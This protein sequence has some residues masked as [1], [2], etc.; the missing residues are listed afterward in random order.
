MTPDPGAQLRHD[1]RTPLNHIIGYSE[2][3]LEEA[4]EEKAA[5]IEQSL[6]RIHA[7]AR[8]LLALVNDLLAP[9]RIGQNAGQLFR[10]PAVMGPLNRLIATGGELRQ[11]AQKAGAER[12]LPDIDRV[13]LAAGN[14]L[15]LVRDEAMPASAAPHAGA[16]P[17]PR[18]R[19]EPASPPKERGR[20]LV[21]DDDENNRDMLSRQIRREGYQVQAAASGRD[22]LRLLET[23]RVDLILLDVMMPDMDGYAVLQRIRVDSPRLHIPVIMISAL[24]DMEGVVRCIELGAEDYLLKP[25]DPVLLRARMSA[26]LEKKRLRDEIDRHVQ[27]MEHELELARS[28]QLSMVPTDFPTPSVEF[29][30]GA[31]ATLQPA[32]EIGGD[33]YDCFWI[34]P[35]RLCLVIADVADKGASA[36]LYMARTKSE[37]RLFATLLGESARRIPGA[38]E[39]VTRV[40]E[41]LCHDNVHAMFVTLFLCIVDSRTGEL[42]WCNAGHHPP[43]LFAADGSLTHLP[44]APNVPVGIEPDFTGISEKGRLAPG[45]TLFL[46]TDGVTEATNERAEFFGEERLR[47]ALQSCAGAA[48]QELVTQVLGEV[49]AFA[50]AAAPSDDIAML[51]CRW[52]A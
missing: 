38:A 3:L 43:Y 1:L 8:Q 14:L 40:N 46:Y 32:R 19:A 11:H 27:R 4:G 31:Y 37:I 49:R 26:C 24:D 12:L 29:P 16:F 20:V 42:D 28:V 25:F 18:A 36:A 52:R 10:I 9:S 15:A 50:G 44:N 21:V 48:P 22:A 45:G 30:L 13:V 35:T 17:A 41:E 6:H 23:E 34:A 2:L 7:D 33:F 39:I 47:I 5:A 51:A